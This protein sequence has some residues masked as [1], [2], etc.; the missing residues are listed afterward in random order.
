MRI[1]ITDESDLWE[2]ARPE[3]EANSSLHG[4]NLRGVL[5]D[6]VSN[7]Q[8]KFVCVK[9]LALSSWM[10]ASRAT[11]WF[12]APLVYVYLLKCDDIDMYKAVAKVRLRAWV[13]LMTEK[14]CEWVIL[15]LPVGTQVRMHLCPL[16]FHYRHH[17][18]LLPPIRPMNVYFCL[19]LLFLAC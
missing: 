3:F 14:Q 8:V 10:V 11:N 1:C 16:L 6:V 5:S 18:H 13:D 17:H 2:S 12:Q 7:F 4:V 19:L 9:E 15:Y